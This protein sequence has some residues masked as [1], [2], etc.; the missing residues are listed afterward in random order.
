MSDVDPKKQL[1][2]ILILKDQ[3]EMR[4]LKKSVLWVYSIFLDDGMTT[5]T[6]P[7][8]LEKTW[9]GRGVRNRHS[10]QVKAGE[11]RPQ[12]NPAPVDM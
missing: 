3:S 11:S 5:P 6:H 2:K 7:L 8:L 9:E 12:E 10:R 4:I 1:G